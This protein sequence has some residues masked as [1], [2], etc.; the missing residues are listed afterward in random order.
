MKANSHYGNSPHRSPYNAGFPS[1]FT[2]SRASLG[3]SQEFDPVQRPVKVPD[4][5][6]T[7]S[8]GGRLHFSWSILNGRLE[9]AWTWGK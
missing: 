1:C 6:A 8:P 7:E 5:K 4:A 9:Q 3:V 2:A